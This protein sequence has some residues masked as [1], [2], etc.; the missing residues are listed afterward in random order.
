MPD[1]VLYFFSEKDIPKD[2]A[3]RSYGEIKYNPAQKKAS[4]L[5]N[6]NNHDLSIPLSRLLLKPKVFSRL[7]SRHYNIEEYP[8]KETAFLETEKYRYLKIHD[9]LIREN[10]D[11]SQ[12]EEIQ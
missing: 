11:G 1:S 2:S 12:K 5:F 8:E 6:A 10:L 9:K 4:I 7:I 3:L